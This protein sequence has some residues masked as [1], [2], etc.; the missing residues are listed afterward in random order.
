V[1]KG[2]KVLITILY[3]VLAA[4]LFFVCFQLF[5]VRNIKVEGSAS[6]DYIKSICGISTGDSTLF[7]DTQKA[8]D[9]IEQ[10]PWLKAV[11]VKIVYPDK[12]VITAQQRQ[13]A[14]YIEKGS[15]LLAI[16]IECVVLRA[17][18]TGE[19]NMPVITGMQMDVFE[20]GKTIGCTDTFLLG[21][22]KRLLGELEGR[23]LDIVKIDLS[24]AANIVLETGSGLYIELGDDTDIDLKL[25]LANAAIAELA[26]KG[27]TAGILDVSA[28]TSAYYREN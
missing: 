4:A 19:V 15:N 16:D 23:Q 26:G 6:P 14:A 9:A 28:V 8:M 7:I 5:R 3:I 27:K 13:I 2:V 12:V 25:D 1:K 11:D 22:A 24:L 17:Q 20:V 18:E 10:E 21:V